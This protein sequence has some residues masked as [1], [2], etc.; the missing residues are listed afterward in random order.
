MKCISVLRPSSLVLALGCALVAVPAFAASYQ[1]D[2]VMTGLVTPR[3]LAFAP[4]GAL[5]VSEAGSGGNGPSLISN[6]VPAYM[7]YTG[8]LSK[9]AGGVQTRV[10]TGLPSLA[11]AGGGE[12]SGL[13]DIVFDAGG[14][15][16]GLF[17]L[18][19]SPAQRDSLGGF[20]ASIF[21]TVSKLSL[22]GTGK[23]TPIAD[24]SAY[25]GANNPDGGMIDTNPFGLARNAAGNFIVADAGG[26]SF[27]QAT[28]A[29]AVSTLGVL[30][31][32]PNPLPFGP[33]V[34]QGVPTSVAI[35]PDGDYY[36]G[37]LTGFPFPAGA[38]DVY[39]YD[40]NTQITSVAYSGFTNIIDLDFDSSGNLYVL[41]ISSNGLA[42]PNGPGTGLL[43]KIDGQTGVRTTIASD[44]LEAPGG[45]AIQ[46]GANGLVF[47]V[48]NHT[49]IPTGGEV[50]RISAVPEPGTWALLLGGLVFVAAIARRRT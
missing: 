31:A 10:L 13:N 11:P 36:I 38:A 16:Y 33:P 23:V 43:L 25:E 50:L 28:D 26:N 30:A 5:Y 17:G 47:Y 48:T 12:A 9:L 7:G 4:D 44:G 18:G 40:P 24:I 21:G 29:G 35:G 15:A 19:S 6:N 41:Q 2:T 27:V 3:G 14:Q 22:D 46:E 20:G 32:K 49:D 34:Y 45:M 8:G 1:I 42:S 37:Q 39:R